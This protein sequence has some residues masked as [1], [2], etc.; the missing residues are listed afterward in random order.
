MNYIKGIDKFYN[1]QYNNVNYY[2]LGDIHKKLP[3]PCPLNQ[4]CDHVTGDFKNILK[5]NKHCSNV[6]ALIYQWINYNYNNNILTDLYI[7]YPIKIDKFE[8]LKY[9]DNDGNK[10]Y[11]SKGFMVDTMM[12]LNDCLNHQ[13]IY[14]PIVKIHRVDPRKIIMAGVQYNASPFILD[15]FENMFNVAKNVMVSKYIKGEDITSFINSIDDRLKDYVKLIYFLVKNSQELLKAAI[16]SDNFSNEIGVMLRKLSIFNQDSIRKKVI[17]TL[18]KMNTLTKNNKYIINTQ[19][20]KIPDDIRNKIINYTLYKNN[21]YIKKL[22]SPLLDITTF[23]VNSFSLE[24]DINDIKKWN[25]ELLTY[26]VVLDAISRIGVK[27]LL[28]SSIYMDCY[29]LARS[30]KYQVDEVIIYAGSTHIDYHI[31]FFNKV[32]KLVEKNDNDIYNDEK[33]CIV[34]DSNKVTKILN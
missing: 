24:N 9:E 11:N 33:T 14:N 25:K 8:L 16:S 30:F 10:S 34:T 29:T 3:D 22:S 5:Y 21:Q 12:M 1:Y 19:L 4:Y 6:T 32:G 17:M 13:C 23:E 2:L 18:S 20:L 27:M 7:E 26:D 15:D 28:L 31:D